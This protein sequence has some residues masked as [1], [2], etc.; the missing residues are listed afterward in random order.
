MRSMKFVNAHR[1]ILLF[2]LGICSTQGQEQDSPTKKFLTIQHHL[3]L[4]PSPKNPRNSEGDFLQLTN[5]KMLFVYTHFTGGASDHAKAFLASRESS[6][7]GKSWTDE[8]KVVVTNEAGMNVMSVSLLRLQSG[9]IALFYLR[10]NST[11]DCRP[12]LRVSTNEAIS[13]S[14]PVECLPGEKGYHVLNNS[15]VIQLASGRLVM[16]LARHVEAGGKWEPG[17]IICLL[18]DDQGKTWQRSSSVL[19]KDANG[20]RVDLMEPGVVEIADGK[21]LMVIRTKLGRQ[22]SSRSDN[23]GETWS[24]PVATDIFSPESPATVRRIPTTGDLLLIWNDHTGK[25]EEYRRSHPP[26][27]TPLSAAISRDAGRTWQNRKI[28]ENDPDSGFCYTAVTFVGNRVLLG[29]CAHK[30]R[31]GL[32]STQISSFDLRELY[33]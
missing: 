15:R 19:D 1:V 2:C 7:G 21:L 3:R 30:S 32:E 31:W 33:R 23:A 4:S 20:T 29:Y 9:E 16:P 8:D 18:S 6:D 10:K 22:F 27:R 12:V 5:G 25:P 17:K 11:D 24:A 26:I 28:I 14:A 13:W